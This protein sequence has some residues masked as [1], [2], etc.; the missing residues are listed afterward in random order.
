MTMSADDIPAL[1]A[2]WERLLARFGS[3]PCRRAAPAELT[4]ATPAE[5]WPEDVPWQR[6]HDATDTPDI[7]ERRDPC[8]KCRRNAFRQRRKDPRVFDCVHCAV[9]RARRQKQRRM[10]RR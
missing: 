2:N 7:V 10:V 6:V 5:A 1:R 3:L 4:L 9:E 8:P